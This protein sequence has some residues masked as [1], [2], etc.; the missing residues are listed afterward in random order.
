MDFQGL[1]AVVT[2]GTSGIGR[3]TS[4]ALAAAGCKVLATGAFERELQACAADRAFAGIGAAQLDVTDNPAVQRYF[5]GLE[6]LDILINAAGVPRGPREFTS[7]GFEF[8]I[9][10]NLNG[11]A[12]C[13]FAAHALLA[14]NGGAIVNVAS[15]M[16]FFGSGTGPAYASSKGGVVQLT[17]SLAVAWGGDNIRCNAVA[18]GFIDTPMT[19]AMQADAERNAKVLARTPMG[20]WGKPEEIAHG[21]LFLASPATTFVNGVVLPVDGGY[22][23][24]AI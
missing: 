8:A 10:V 16:S 12:R 7:E 6:R 15:M 9:D 20:R 22:L 14:R 24:T 3:A 11:S 21:I 1:T 17:K 23:T 19:Q 18:P 5:G 13:C 2:G 4:L